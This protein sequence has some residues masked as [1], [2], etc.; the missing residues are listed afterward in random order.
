MDRDEI[1][2]SVKPKENIKC[3]TCA[4]KLDDVVVAGKLYKRHTYGNCSM[5]EPPDTKPN[6]VLFEGADCEFYVKE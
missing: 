5:Y 2:T 4:F 6:A 1:W 3:K